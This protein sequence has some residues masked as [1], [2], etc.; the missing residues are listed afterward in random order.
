MIMTGE[1]AIDRRPGAS[2]RSA[3]DVRPAGARDETSVRDAGVA[4]GRA[5]PGTSR[6]GT[7]MSHASRR[8]ATRHGDDEA[9][10]ATK[11]TA[12]SMLHPLRR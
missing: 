5:R 8:G 10:P 1:S 9:G 3:A 7:G 2:G 11:I 4:D 12:P 6:C